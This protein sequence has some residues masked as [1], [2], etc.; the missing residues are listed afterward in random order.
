M[1][2]DRVIHRWFGQTMFTSNEAIV[3]NAKK[4]LR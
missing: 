3:K 4:R 1:M 2:K